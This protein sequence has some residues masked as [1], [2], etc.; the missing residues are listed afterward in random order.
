M[1]DPTQIHQILLNL[2]TNAGHAMRLGGGA[3]SLRLEDIEIA[4]ADVQTNPDF[5][6]GTYIKLS[7]TDTGIGMEANIIDR[8]FDPF[9]TTKPKGEGTGMGLALVHGIVKS[10]SGVITVQSQPGTGTTVNVFIPIITSGKQKLKPDTAPLPTGTERIL[11][12]DDEGPLVE[13]AQTMLKRLGYQ[14]T[15]QTSSVEALRLFE[16]DPSQFDLIITDLTMPAIPGD[17]LAAQTKALRPDIPIIMATGFSEQIMGQD[18][19]N[20]GI[21]KIVLK[22]LLMRDIAIAIRE[23]L[24]DDSID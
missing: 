7:V 1:G 23:V 13:I 20:L 8:I 14:V 22:P 11:F 2:C 9:F 24:D 4:A 18:L 16:H 19:L 21:A 17:K 12:V 5:K 6:V 15:T 10:Y 3:L